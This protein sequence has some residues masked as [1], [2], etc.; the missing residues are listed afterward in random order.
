ML[1]NRSSLSQAS[2]A[3]F[4]SRLRLLREAHAALSSR[5]NSPLLPG[6]GVVTRYADPVL[7]AAH[8]PLHW[9][10][11]LNPETNP[12]L[13]E[14]LGI[15]AVFNAGAIEWEGRICLMLRVEGTDRKSFFAVAESSSGTGGFRFRDLPVQIPELPGEPETN[16]YDMRLTRHADGYIYGVF[17]TE[18]HDESR[19][20]DPAAA[21]A[22]CGIIR[23]RDLEHWERLPNLQT[24]SPQQR[25]CVL[26]PEFVQGQYAF[27]TRPMD[28]FLTASG[29]GGIGWGLCEDICRPVIREERVIDPRRYHTISELKNGQGPPPIRTAAGWLHLAHGVRNTAA[30]MRY[31]LYLLLTSLED[32]A[33]VVRAPGGYLLAPEGDERT[34]DVS[35]VLFSNGWVERSSGEVLIYYA[36]SDTRMHVAATSVAQLLDYALHTPEDSG[37]SHGSA[38][39]RIAL[40]RQNRQWLAEETD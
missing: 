35:N 37:S 1:Q 10:Y 33:Q 28:G 36:S 32:P 16:L 3:L 40:I 21:I 6:N 25:N 39:Q 15:N 13:M 12:W 19:P 17:C 38:A 29:G 22:Q 4:G 2:P 26:H 24:P 9:R 8:V 23:S 7:T 34:G 30:G 14:R 18:R 27:Y 11:D 31:V 5:P 20:E